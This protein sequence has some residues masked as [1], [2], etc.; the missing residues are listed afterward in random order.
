MAIVVSAENSTL[1]DVLPMSPG[2]SIGSRVVNVETSGR[3]GAGRRCCSAPAAR[4]IFSDIGGPIGVEESPAA[5][6]CAI[7]NA[8]SYSLSAHL[9]SACTSRASFSLSMS[10]ISKVPYKMMHLIRP[11]WAPY[12][13]QY[14]LLFKTACSIN[15]ILMH[16]WSRVYFVG[17]RC[18]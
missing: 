14:I 7:S 16:L 2:N 11:L 15:V 17:G 5:L 10:Q 1:R 9:S 18:G 8:L 4:T 6:F 3:L 12:K 13:V